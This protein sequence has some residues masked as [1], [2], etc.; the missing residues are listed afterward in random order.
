[1]ERILYEVSVSPLKERPRL[2]EHSLR[3]KIA[4]HRFG[5]EPE[6]VLIRGGKDARAPESCDD[7]L[8]DYARLRA[9]IGRRREWPAFGDRLRVIDN[10]RARLSREDL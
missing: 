8:P 1:M 4:R 6:H 9:D 2:D 7:L 5:V 10:R 3:L